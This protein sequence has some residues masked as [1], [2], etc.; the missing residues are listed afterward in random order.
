MLTG[1]VLAAL[2]VAAGMA[3]RTGRPGA[4][5]LAVVSVLWLVVNKSMEGPT[6]VRISSTHGLVA[7][8]LAGVAGVV[9]AA[10]AWRRGPRP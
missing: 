7:A 6:L 9:V 8:D 10:L 4:V 2:V 3:G 5:A 1:L